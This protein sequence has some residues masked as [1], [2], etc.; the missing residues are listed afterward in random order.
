M[1]IVEG[2]ADL[3]FVYIGGGC[4]V[5]VIII[6]ILLIYFRVHGEKQIQAEVI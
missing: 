4:I 6:I 2:D 3:T 1:W 5:M